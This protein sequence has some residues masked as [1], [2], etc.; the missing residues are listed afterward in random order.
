M[1]NESR[2]PEPTPPDPDNE[3]EGEIRVAY[4]SVCDREVRV[5]V[6][7]PPGVE[8]RDIPSSKDLDSIVCLDVGDDCT[9]AFCPF[10]E[11]P[12]V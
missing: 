8:E 9:G 4:C 3:H 11:Q 12:S 6:R 7:A 1:S 5:K 10:G 2:Q